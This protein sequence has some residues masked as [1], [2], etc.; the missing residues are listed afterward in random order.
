VGHLSAGEV[1]ETLRVAITAP[2]HVRV[3]EL[4]VRSTG[5]SPDY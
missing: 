1:A 3:E 4:V 5:Q 2:D